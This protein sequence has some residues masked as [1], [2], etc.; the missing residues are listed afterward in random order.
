MMAGAAELQ[1]VH[2]VRA[3]LREGVDD[4]LRLLG[5][6]LRLEDPLVVRVVDAEAVGHVD[7]LRVEDDGPPDDESNGS[8][9][10]PG[11]LAAGDADELAVRTGARAVGH[12]EY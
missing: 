10:L 11:E 1:T 5:H 8:I 3:R 12:V 6:P 4:L 2:G 9:D 7:G